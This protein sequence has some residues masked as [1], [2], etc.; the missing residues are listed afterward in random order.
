MTL[1]LTLLSEQWII[2]ASDRRLTDAL[3]RVV[4]D[5]S[6]KA[7]FWCSNHVIAYTGLAHIGARPALA[8]LS[9]QLSKGGAYEPRLA[10]V[11]ASADRALAPLA[12]R[13]HLKRVAFI[14]AG[15]V[16]INDDGELRP[17]LTI[18]SNYYDRLGNRY[19]NAQAKFD[20]HH[21]ACPPNS[22][23]FHTT[24]PLPKTFEEPLRRAVLKSAQ[25]APSPFPVARLLVHL[26]D[27]VA[28][29][30]RSVGKNIMCTILPRPSGEPNQ[31]FSIT[32]GLVP[33]VTELRRDGE[34]FRTPRGWDATPHY[35]Y[36]AYD[37]TQMPYHGPAVVCGDVQIREITFKEGPP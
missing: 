9:E 24:G 30:E 13:P 33:L 27:R 6:N 20:V 10:Q 7:L 29:R 37:A 28:Q 17:L 31:Q 21:E 18:V 8:W 25:R 26:V 15:F 1:I 22:F 11:A 2:Q 16:R 32:S 5:H 4:E 34:Y 3:G 19:P 12:L 14:I 36:R 23:L 35:I